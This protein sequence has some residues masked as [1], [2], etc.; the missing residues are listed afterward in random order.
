MMRLSK[1]QASDRPVFSP[2][3]TAPMAHVISENMSSP[4]D[5]AGFFRNAETVRVDAG[6]VIVRHRD[7]GDRFYL[8]SEGMAEVW[9]PDIESDE[10][11]CVARL[12]AG[13]VFGEEAILIEGYR[14]A[15]VRMITPGV[16]KVMEKDV[17]NNGLRARLLEEVTPEQA[18]IMAGRRDT[19]W[20]DCRFDIEY[21]GTHIPGACLMP[22]HTLREA[23]D[24]LDHDK[25]YLVYCQCGK[26]SAC[27]A[28]LLRER[29]YNAI[30]V[31]GGIRDWPYVLD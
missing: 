16:L 19:D 12:G 27:A 26:R 10:W 6:S 31:T 13:D 17:F 4:V 2:L 14:N 8:I 29:G 21:S 9:K 18:Q 7:P 30:S 24:E 3:T 22:L 23:A 11:S 15:T 28:Y 20:L 25:R 5:V 1:E